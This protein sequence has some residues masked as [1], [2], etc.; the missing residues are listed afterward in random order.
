MLNKLKYLKAYW[1]RNILPGPDNI[2]GKIVYT[3]KN[4]TGR[5]NQI[6]F[7]LDADVTAFTTIDPYPADILTFP[8]V[9]VV[10]YN[11]NTPKTDKELYIFGGL[12][13]KPKIE[14]NAPASYKQSIKEKTNI[15]SINIYSSLKINGNP[16]TTKDPMTIKIIDKTNM[17]Y[18]DKTGNVTLIDNTKIGVH[19]LKFTATHKI[20][21]STHVEGY[22]QI[23]ITK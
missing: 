8:G 21:P 1:Q 11:N 13:I 15:T 12:D 9:E 4:T 16:T 2:V 6:I 23:T 18:D 17:Y 5:R 7:D 19:Y 14:Y 3:S 20:E 22:I 10:K